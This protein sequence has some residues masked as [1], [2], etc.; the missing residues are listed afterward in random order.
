MY[1][2]YLRGKMYELIALREF[3]QRYSC[4][5]KI[6]PIIEPVRNELKSVAKTVDALFGSNIG[7]AVVLNPAQGDFERVSAGRSIVDTLVGKEYIPAFLMGSNEAVVAQMIADYKLSKVMLIFTSGFDS[8]NSALMALAESEDVHYFVGLD[9]RSLKRRFRA[10]GKM[11]ISL[12][13]RFKKQP[14]NKD[15]R[16]TED[17]F[18]SDDHAFF[19]DEQVDGFSDYCV[20]P[21]EF[22]KGGMVPTYLAIHLS[23]KKSEDEVWVHHFVS[24]TPTSGNIQG[25][26]QEAAE[27]VIQFYEHRP[28]THAINEMLDYYNDGKF[29]GLGMLKKYTI[30]NHLELMHGL[31]DG[32][33]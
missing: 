7:C 9:N 6:V 27:K 21:S 23:Y 17:E 19:G 8:E 22:I 4:E 30:A 12:K 18:Y 28:H 16:G 25:K 26:F 32:G 10:A 14:T 3:A 5:Q 13:D 15:Y 33:N 1:Y 31:M 24:D 29:P 20:L 11:V 2:P